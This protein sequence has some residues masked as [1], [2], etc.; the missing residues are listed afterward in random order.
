MTTFRRGLGY[1]SVAPAILAFC[2]LVPAGVRAQQDTTFQDVVKAIMARPA[3]EHSIWGLEVYSLDDHQPL[4]VH[5]GDKLFTPA[6]TT[7]LVTEGTALALL[8]A[9]HRFKTRVYR[10]GPIAADGTLDGDIVL[11]ASGDPDLSNRI[12]PDGTLAFENEDHAYDGSK[13]TK[14]VPGDPL[15]VIRQLAD[16]IAKHGIKRVTGHVLVDVSLFPEGSRELGSGVVISP[17]AVNDNLVD[18]TIGPGDSLSAPLTIQPSPQTSYVQFVNKTETGPADSTKVEIHWAHDST[19]V[20]GSHMVTVTGSMPTGSQPWLFSYA[21]P[22]PSRFAEVVLSEALAEDGVSAEPPPY[23]EVVDFQALSSSYTPDHVVAE[24][25]SPPFSQELKV[26]LKVSQNLHASMTP[27][28]LGSVLGG[29]NQNAEKKGFELERDF[30]G[31][32]GLDLSGASQGDGAG[33][34][35][36]AFFAPDFMVRYLA[37]MRER[38]DFNDLYNALPVLGVDGTLWNI[39]TH[40]PAVGHVH[41]KTGTFGA[42]DKLNQHLILTAKGLAGYITTVNGRHLAFAFYLNRVP[43]PS[44]LEDGV[45]KIAGQ[46]LGEI[47]A[48]AYAYPIAPSDTA[49]TG[50]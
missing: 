7:K 5:N 36:S 27:Y 34:A 32:L 30:L 25:T 33:G 47:A 23:N 42:Y 26:T 40:S 41:A 39:Q 17:V 15:Q 13:Y 8:G 4:Y 3:F 46:T 20:D 22:Q 19:M 12:Q 2:V 50:H 16:Q 6:S 37:A 48:A 1:R 29:E 9:D 10:T 43:I 35:Q 44:D 31:K 18:V 21:V 14:A 45:T 49:T 24:H 38:D 11:V 28:I